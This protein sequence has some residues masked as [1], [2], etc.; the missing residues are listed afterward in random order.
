[1]NQLQ[2]ETSSFDW[3]PRCWKTL[4]N[5]EVVWTIRKT[6]VVEGVAA[7]AV[8]VVVAAVVAVAVAVAAFKWLTL[9]HS[10]YSFHWDK[11]KS[12]PFSQ[13]IS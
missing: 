6:G 11:R 12:L 10:Y 1:M 2:I 9:T 7:V 5:F 4:E 3:R 13:K 8:V